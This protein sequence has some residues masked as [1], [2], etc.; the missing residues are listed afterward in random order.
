MKTLLVLPPERQHF[1]LTE[2]RQKEAADKCPQESLF[3]E[4]LNADVIDARYL[5]SWR[6]RS[7]F[8][9]FFYKIIPLLFLQALIVYQQR[10]HYDVVISWDDRFA[11][12]YALLL[13]LTRSRSRHVAIL[14]WMPPPKKALT[15]RLVQKGIDRIVLW[16]QTQSDLLVEFCNIAP[17]RIVVIP[18]WVDHNFWRPM[19]EA[20]DSIC[21]V[22]DSRRDYT[23]LIEAVRGLDIRCNIATRVKLAEAANPDWGATGRSLAQVSSLP[24]NVGCQSASLTELRTMYARARFVVLPLLPTFR[25]SGITVVTEAMA[26]GKAIIC[27][28]IQGQIEFLEE[29]V[30]GIFVPPGDPQALREA[31]QYLWEHPDVAAQMGREGRRRAEEIFKLTQFVTNVRQIVDDVIT[32]NRTSI[33][34]MAERM[35]A[36]SHSKKAAAAGSVMD[37]LGLGIAPAPITDSIRMSTLSAEKSK[38]HDSTI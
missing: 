22:G 23:T 1:R 29:G 15:L 38:I 18:Y 19:N 34:T 5:Q 10:R 21:S 27:S 3:E 12:I 16:S 8:T 32:G 11:L 14:S 24:A 13:R 25:D 7:L 28:R 37:P 17:A 36:L 4:T 30:T 26:M 31:I 9:R 35:H 33:P 6:S 2:Q 20:A